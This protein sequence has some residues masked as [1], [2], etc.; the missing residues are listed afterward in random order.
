LKPSFCVALFLGVRLSP[1]VFV[2]HVF[3]SFGLLCAGGGLLELFVFFF[4]PVRSSE[5]PMLLCGKFCHVVTHQSS[6]YCRR[7]RF[8]CVCVCVHESRALRLHFFSSFWVGSV[9]RSFG[10]WFLGGS[11]PDDLVLPDPEFW[12]KKNRVVLIVGRNLS[13]ITGGLCLVQGWIWFCFFLFFNQ[14]CFGIAF[15]PPGPCCSLKLLII[16]T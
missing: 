5:L 13:I 9:I 16:S 8:V 2:W 3:L 10:D 4:L 12:Q 11:F 7:F 1:F 15:W 14:R 6:C